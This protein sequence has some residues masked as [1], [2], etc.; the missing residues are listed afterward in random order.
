VLRAILFDFNGVLVDD[1][2]VHLELFQRV[3]ADEGIA[4]SAG[5][6]YTRYLGLDDR[7]GFAAMLAAAGEAATVPRLMRLTARKASYYQERVRRYRAEAGLRQGAL[8]SE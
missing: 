7:A 6:Y 5:D 3:L 8:G 4:L 1:E 2:P